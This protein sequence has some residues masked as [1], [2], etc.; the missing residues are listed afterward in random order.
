[1][2]ALVLA[3][4]AALVAGCGSASDVNLDNAADATSADTSRFELRYEIT[5]IPE[6]RSFTVTARGLFDFP[7]ERGVM[8]VGGDFAT[9]A[10]L[11]EG[12]S[13][14]EFRLIEK[15]GYTRWIVKGKSYWVKEA[16]DDKSGDAAELLIPLPGTPTKPTDVLARVLEASTENHK[17]GT[18]EV[19]G[20]ETT[21]FRASV[22][23]RKLVDQLPVAER[24]ADDA[25]E[26]WGSRFVPVEIWIDGESRLRR[27]TLER[28]EDEATMSTRVELF[29]Y[30]VDVDVEPPPAD[31]VISREEFD[32]LARDS[33]AFTNTLEAGEAEQMPPPGQPGN[34]ESE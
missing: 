24:P 29:D 3:A 8:S 9:L 21:H 28:G 12:V 27:I 30:G 16:I 5:G 13:F 34:K 22:D 25:V 4:F 19:G 1:V 10:G 33:G 15:A 2:R 26:A 17:L 23:L 14:E 11:A 31:E 20:A 32:K 18:E 7:N 6:K